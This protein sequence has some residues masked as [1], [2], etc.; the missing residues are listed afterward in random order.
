MECRNLADPRE[1]GRVRLLS[2]LGREIVA[3]RAELG[4]APAAPR[5]DGTRR[6]ASKRALLKV[7]EDA[8]GRW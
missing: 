7:I 6:T 8:G 3:R 4:D 2:D 1:P 5:N